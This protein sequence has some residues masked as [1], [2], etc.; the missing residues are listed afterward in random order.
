MKLL[1]VE[2]F[3]SWQHLRYQSAQVPTC[4]SVHSCWLYSAAPLGKKPGHHYNELISN[5]YYSDTEPASHCPILI[6]SGAWLVSKKYQFLSHW[7]FSTKIQSHILPKPDIDAQLIRPSRLMEWACIVGEFILK[8]VP[9]SL[10]P[11]CGSLGSP[12]TAPHTKY[13]RCE[14]PQILQRSLWSVQSSQ[15]GADRPSAHG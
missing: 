13:N 3:T 12:A 1:V 6:M 4:S 14:D 7:F 2:S 15:V 10:S 9:T 11:N 8:Q 5:P